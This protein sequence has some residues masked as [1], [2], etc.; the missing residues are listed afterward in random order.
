MRISTKT[1]YGMRLMINLAANFKNGYSFLKDI[2]KSEGI[3]EKYL[4]LIV[5][6][7]RTAGLLKTTR[8]VHGGYILS[9]DP[10]EITAGQVVEILEG[11]LSLVECIKNEKYCIKLKNCA[12]R[13]IWFDLGKKMTEFLNSLTLKDLAK[14]QS[15][16]KSVSMDYII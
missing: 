9:K 10:S 5:I 6:P 8:G 16:K 15:E 12:S 2:A 11:D 4:S 7:L 3:S 13:D 14:L 1:R